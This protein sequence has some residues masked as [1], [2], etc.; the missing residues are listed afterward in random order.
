M[1]HFQPYIET[2]KGIHERE[3]WTRRQAARY[4]A[5]LR[6]EHAT[7]TQV[8]DVRIRG[9]LCADCEQ[10]GPFY[11]GG[12]PPISASSWEEDIAIEVGEDEVESIKAAVE[13]GQDPHWTCVRCRRS[14]RPWG[15]DDVFIVSR[16]LDENYDLE[17]D[18]GTKKRPSQAM[19]DLVL[20]MYEY[21]CFGCGAHESSVELTI[22]H[23]QPRSRGGDAAFRNLQ[24]LCEPCQQKK[25]NAPA[26]DVGIHHD[27]L[28]VD[29]GDSYEGLFW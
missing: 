3:V 19:R 10:S 16:F 12:L 15:G 25:A 18:T 7:V 22:D 9:P 11:S 2:D 24:P 21:R 29:P 13:K 27:M 5:N 26:D 8:I 28:F 23:I 6:R 4:Y 14:L 1:P 17:S 20:E